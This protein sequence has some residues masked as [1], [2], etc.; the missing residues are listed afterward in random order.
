MLKV[1]DYHGV[2]VADPYKWLED[3]DSEQTKV[4][5]E[6][7]SIFVHKFHYSLFYKLIKTDI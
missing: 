7:Y 5:M 4:T 3:P 2:K 1:D 6:H